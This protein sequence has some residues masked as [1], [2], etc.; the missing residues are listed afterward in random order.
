MSATTAP[1]AG[2]SPDLIL[3]PPTLDEAIQIRQRNQPDWGGAL[4]A[5]QYLEREVFLETIPLARDGGKRT[6]ILT[7]PD[8]TAG[9]RPIL[10]SCETWKKAAL[11]T[12]PGSDQVTEAVSYGIGSVY[13]FSEHRGH[14]YASRLLRDLHALL[15][16]GTDS[17]PPATATVLW[18]DIGKKF[19]SKIGWAAH[20]S[21]HAAISTGADLTGSVP[22]A[23]TSGTITYENL[24]AFSNADQESLKKT[25]SAR[26]KAGERCFA[27]NPDYDT[28]Q[29]ALFRDEWIAKKVFPDQEQEAVKGAWAGETGRRVWATWGRSYTE[30]P[31]TPDK[32]TLYIFRLAVEDETAPAEELASSLLSV[33][34]TAAEYAKRWHIGSVYLWNPTPAVHAA[35]EKTGVAFTIVDRQDDSIPSLFFKDGQESIT[36]VGNEKYG[37]C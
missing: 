7:N 10:A 14:G 2:D 37:W 23:K 34:Q 5:E 20:P 6:W 3:A 28:L 27:L 33:L 21:T 4:T 24:E 35:L 31:P 1:R 32:N 22:A 15:R 11:T 17:L 18:S 30:N 25:L 19:Y 9:Q 16:K 36:W 8:L 29:W 26:G 13:T 12:E